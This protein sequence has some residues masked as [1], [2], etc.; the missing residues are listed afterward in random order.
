V[1]TARLRRREGGRIWATVSGVISQNSH[2]SKTLIL[3]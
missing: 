2:L 1:V 3:S